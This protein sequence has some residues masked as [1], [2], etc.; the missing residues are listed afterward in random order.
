VESSNL[1]K[2][3]IAKKNLEGNHNS[4]FFVCDN[5][6]KIQSLF[7]EC[8]F[9]KTIWSIIHMSFALSPPTNTTNLFT[10]WLNGV[11]KKDKAKS[12]SEFF[13]R[14]TRTFFLELIP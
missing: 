10:N 14:S 5:D 6:E 7:I 12:R 4:R 8:P 2:D 1:D 13:N 11:G 3:N 9:A